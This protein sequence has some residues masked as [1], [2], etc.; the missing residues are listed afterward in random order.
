MRHDL[1]RY[2]R[3]VCKRRSHGADHAGARDWLGQNAEPLITSDYVVDE[4][5]TLLKVRGE[6]RRAIALG[7]QFFS[8]TLCTV[9]HLTEVDILLTWEMFRRFTDKGWSFTDCGSKVLIE[10]LNITRAFAF[11]QHFR[12]FGSVNVVP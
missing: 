1:R 5:L 8:G 3:V 11:D 7:E 4:T 6:G 10:K 2:G 12:Q 9:Y